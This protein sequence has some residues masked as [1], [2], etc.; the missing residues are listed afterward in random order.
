M[1]AAAQA[2]RLFGY[3]FAQPES[4]RL[5]PDEL[6]SLPPEAAILQ[7]FFGGA[8]I[9]DRRWEIVARDAQF[10]PARWPQLPLAGA[11]RYAGAAEI[12]RRLRSAL[13]GLSQERPQIVCQI[14][15]PFDAR[16]LE[17]LACGGRVQIG[18]R[19]PEQQMRA[20]A[21]AIESLPGIELCV[22][23]TYDPPFDL[24][25]LFAFARIESLVLDC[26]AVRHP[27]AICELPQL[28]RL[29]VRKAALEGALLPPLPELRALRLVTGRA[30]PQSLWGYTALERLTL[31]NVTGFEACARYPPHLNELELLHGSYDVTEV[32]ALAHLRTLTIRDVRLR[33]FPG[34]DRSRE[35]V[36]VQL[37]NVRLLDDLAPLARIPNLR[38]LSIEEM[39]QLA[40]EDF[41]V[42]SALGPID[43]TVDVGSR[44][45]NREIYRLLRQSGA[46]KP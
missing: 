18:E 10:D 19:L 11:P 28:R 13:Q 32:G 26:S 16:S 25:A 14:R 2:S 42:F 38:V 6:R 29:S 34:L 17:L 23:G 3:F 36:R 22:H 31:S 39:P 44:S 9:E 46:R 41:E 21:A 8:A 37:R 7:T 27:E 24:R 20:L 40:I 30:E 12:E 4:D 5:H 43:I 45:R 35:L 15:A 1:V 33:E